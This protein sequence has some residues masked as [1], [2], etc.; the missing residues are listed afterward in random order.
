MVTIIIAIIIVIKCHV[1]GMKKVQ[2]DI[3]QYKPYI[4]INKIPIPAVEISENFTYLGKDLNI[5][6]NCDHVTKQLTKGIT[7]YLRKIYILPLH[8]LQKIEICQ[9]YVFSKLKSRFTIYH[10]NQTWVSQNTDNQFSK[11]YRKWLQLPACANIK[12]LSL[13]NKKLGMNVKT[14]KSIYN[15]CKI[16]LR[17]VLKCSINEEARKLYEITT[18]KNVNS[19]SIVNKAFSQ[20]LPNNKIKAKCKSILNKEITESVWDN[21]MGLK[22]QFIL[23]KQIFEVSMIKYIQ[24]WKILVK[25]LPINIHNFC[26]RY[27]VMSFANN[28]NLKRWKISNSELC[29]LCTKKQTQLHDFN[30]CLQALNRYTWRH[31]LI[32]QTFC[33][34][35]LKK[36][37]YDFR[38]YAD[39]ES[40][41]NPATLFKPRQ[42]SLTTTAPQQNDLSHLA[43]P[44]IAI[45]IR[46]TFDSN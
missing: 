37:S 21:F 6:M 4:T 24:S 26:R 44:D 46:D 29:S 14:T 12:H 9:L 35:L 33:S 16:T 2:T 45:E 34:H 39:I 42:Q 41:E 30:H 11:Y 5:S 31:N 40:F 17:R 8:P 36:A 25:R 10:L 28:S 1:F 19:D 27:S 43:R 38:L 22:E 13:P 18:M 3:I 23:R 32:I 20:D 7:N 15:E